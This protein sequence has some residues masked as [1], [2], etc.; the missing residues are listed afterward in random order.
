[1]SSAA[2]MVVGPSISGLAETQGPPEDEGGDMGDMYHAR[3][4]RDG[5]C[6]RLMVALGDILSAT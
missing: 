2:S 5:Y 6:W 3:F 1:M 4:G